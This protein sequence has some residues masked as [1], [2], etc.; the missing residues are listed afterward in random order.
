MA[1]RYNHLAARVC[2]R[3]HRT[4]IGKFCV[5]GIALVQ[6]GGQLK[7]QTLDA[8]GWWWLLL[9]LGISWISILVNGAAWRLLLDW[10]G[11]RPAPHGAVE[12]QVH[13][14]CCDRHW[15]E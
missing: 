2:R 11:H 6:Q 10:L 5:L 15:R 9:G 13:L 4:I 3:T 8:R 7:E 14:A 12:G 1:L